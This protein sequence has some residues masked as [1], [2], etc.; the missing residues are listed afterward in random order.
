MEVLM[1]AFDTSRS[2]IDI[3]E[4]AKKHAETVHHSLAI[5]QFLVTILC[6]SYMVLETRQSYST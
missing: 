6:G 1:E 4:V 3:T 2:L 5:M